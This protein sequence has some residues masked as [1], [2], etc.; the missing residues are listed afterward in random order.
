MEQSDMSSAEESES[1]TNIM[2]GNYAKRPAVHATSNAI[3]PALV[4]DKRRQAM[5]PT[6]GAFAHKAVTMTPLQK[7]LADVKANAKHPIMKSTKS[8]DRKPPI[9]TPATKTKYMPSMY[10]AK[11]EM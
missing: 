8:L 10:Y 3:S 1:D 4:P 7:H 6:P 2:L 5:T 11:S 9:S